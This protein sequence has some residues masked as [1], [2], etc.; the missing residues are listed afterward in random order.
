MINFKL[1][2]K[3]K[4]NYSGNENNMFVLLSLFHIN[5][6]IN[7]SSLKAQFKSLREGKLL[8]KIGTYHSK[9]NDRW[10][11]YEN[12]FDVYD[13]I[14]ESMKNPSGKVK[15]RL[16]RINKLKKLSGLEPK[17]FKNYLDFEE[18]LKYLNK[19]LNKNRN[20]C[21]DHLY[22][23]FIKP[24]I[25]NYEYNSST[26]KNLL[27]QDFSEFEYNSYSS[28]DEYYCCEY[29]CGE[30]SD[31]LEH[32]GRER[33]REKYKNASKEILNVVNKFLNSKREKYKGSYKQFTL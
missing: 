30:Y 5:G 11:N 27:G 15:L 18:T 25:K 33:D 16:E 29:C 9:I 21:I 8:R 20:Y 6:L 31:W 13:D 23:E 26:I 14:F 22:N 3:I 4:Y 7:D 12:I 19:Y 24:G 2:H 1:D 32:K 28:Y 17:L 10:Y